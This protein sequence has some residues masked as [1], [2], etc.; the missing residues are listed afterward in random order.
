[1]NDL[2]KD[3]DDTR[4]VKIV[5]DEFTNRT[6]L[7]KI[8][9][10]IKQRVD[11]K[12]LI[13]YLAKPTDR[14]FKIL[15][16]VLELTQVDNPY[17]D[18]ATIKR[19]SA[20]PKKRLELAEVQYLRT[21]LSESLT[22]TRHSFE[23]DFFDRYIFSV[24]GAEEQII[25]SGNHIVYGRRGSGKSSLLAYL[26]NNLR[27]K[28]VPHAWVAMQAYAG[29]RDNL[30]IVDVLLELITQLYDQHQS[31]SELSFLKN[32]LNALCDMEE[33]I[34]LTHVDRLIPRI[35]RTLF[36]LTTIKDR[37]V[38]FLDDIHVIHKDLQPVLLSKLYSICRDNKVFL[39]ISG[40]EQFTNNWDSSSRQGME[41]PHDAQVIRLDYNLT[42]PDK[43][44]KHIQSILDA[45]AKY[46]GLPNINYV[47][48]DGVLSRLAWVAAGVPR[49]ALN[50][51]AQAI[52]RA[53]MRELNKVSITNINAA[54]S[55]MAEDKL[56]DIQKDTTG[57][58]DNAKLTLESIK[59][60]CIDTQRKNAFLVEIRNDHP[61]FIDIQDLVALRLLHVLHE[62][63][64][65]SDAGRRFMAFM[66]DYGFYIGIRAARSVD[67]FQKEPS[68]I[69]AKDIRALPIFKYPKS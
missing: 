38:I 9:W 22:V 46:C 33:N 43:S 66:L 64:T 36:P 6:R 7:G 35:R 34:I 61:L 31:S 15:N 30:V 59:K 32:K 14:F 49:D 29:R 57:Q 69:Q 44:R 55:E 47:C 10:E 26:L 28:R 17:R 60:F 19:R 51:F 16:D 56:K 1:M 21:I 68:S 2:I 65:P 8:D 53:N 48:G 11:G 62:G 52:S 13:I 50:I 41:I 24:F 18:R 67:L 5:I 40:I 12:Y 63:I 27:L 58:F 4:Y 45:H 20:S 25:A 54:A 37:I 23:D 39:K 42:M 3:T